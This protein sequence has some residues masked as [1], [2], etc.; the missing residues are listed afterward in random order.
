[1]QLSGCWN[2]QLP[3]LA[4]YFGF[5]SFS[6]S[7]IDFF[8]IYHSQAALFFTAASSACTTFEMQIVFAVCLVSRGNVHS[9]GYLTFFV[10]CHIFCSTTRFY[11][12][13]ALCSETCSSWCDSL[14][15]AW[16]IFV[17]QL[18]ESCVS[19]TNR[20]KFEFFKF[21]PI[22]K[23]PEFSKVGGKWKISDFLLFF[24]PLFAFFKAHAGINF[25]FC[26]I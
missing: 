26:S 17:T 25:C 14:L 7:T 3:I 21:P 1:M 4:H 2:L 11:G 10:A 15:V 16:L 18:L 8:P 13:C 20:R 19:C 24:Y 5:G 22:F 12:S 6:L 9:S 23:E